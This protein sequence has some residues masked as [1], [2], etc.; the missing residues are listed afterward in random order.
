MA[1]TLGDN[2][3]YLGTKPLDGRI[4]YS[5]IS[6]MVA[7][8]DT[9]LYDGIL[10]YC[11]EDGKNYQWKSTNDVDVTLGKW[12]EFSSGGG[13]VDSVNGQTGVVVLDAE[14]VGALP[15]N[16]S[17]PDSTS[18]LTNDSGFITNTVNNLVNYYLK[19]ETYTQAEVNALIS[20]IVTLDIQAVSTLPTENISRTTIYLVPSADPQTQ[21]I[22]DEYINLDGTSSGWELIGS[23]EIDLTGYVTDTELTT[24]LADYT[25]TANLT[26][27]L[28][29]KVDKVTGKQ[30][31]TEDYTTAEKT[32]LA[33]L[34]NIQVSTMPTASASNEGDIVQYVG[35]TTSTYTNGYFYECVEDSGSY[36]WIA[37]SVQAGGSGVND[38]E[39]LDN[40]PSINGTQLVGN[41][42]S[43]DLDLQDIIQL[44]TMPTLSADINGKIYQYVGDTTS[45]FTQGKF[46]KAIYINVISYYWSSSEVNGYTLALPTNELKVGDNFYRDADC[47]NIYAPVNSVVSNTQ[48]TITSP[49][50]GHP[51][52]NYTGTTH[53]IEEDIRWEEVITSSADFDDVT[54]RPLE[55]DA[56]DIDD[57][58]L[59][60][61]A[62]PT[63]YPI[64]FDETGTEYQ[65]GLYKRASD[66]KVKPVWRKDCYNLGAFTATDLDNIDLGLSNVDTLIYYKG[67]TKI[68][69]AT[70]RHGLVFTHPSGL[71]YS[72]SY[73][74]NNNKLGARRGSEVGSHHIDISV[75]FTKTTDE[76][77]E[78]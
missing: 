70:I 44:D 62:K 30:L 7:M 21:N 72:Y 23:T 69:N 52:T 61:P 74:I 75:F 50:G 5:T 65:A 53:T 39:D 51:A 57:L 3:S 42:T 33:S 78:V 13:A 56:I 55:S 1:L 8:S 49:Y 15:D 41:K 48:I 54:N 37:K 47:T 12:R 71:Q 24:A 60:M 19:S 17:I 6:E 20:A 73:Y 38:Y 58:D 2:F 36:S 9:T 76:W 29:G 46:Y 35:T 27:L 31:S 11:V 34:E 77:K 10:A 67:T 40:L 14:D 64:L 26:T 63:E 66:G 25:T 45:N 59:P 18:D 4:K 32:K 28:N 43:A 22:K 68:D 16:T